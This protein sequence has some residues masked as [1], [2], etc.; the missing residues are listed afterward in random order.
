MKNASLLLL[1]TILVVVSARASESKMSYLDN[2]EIRLGVDLSKGGAVTYLAD[3][4]SKENVINSWDWGRQI[5][6]SFYSGPVPFAPD[7]ATLAP[8]WKDLGWNPIQS[9]DHYK[10]GSQVVEYH[11]DGKTIFVRCIPMI[12]P[13]DNV[14]AESFFETTYKLNGRTVEVTARLINHREDT[15]QYPARQQELPA[16][17]TNGPWYRLVTYMGDRPFTSGEVTALV[18]RE[19]GKGWPWLQFY[20]SERWA[21]LLNDENEGLGVYHPSACWMSGGFAGI[22]GA[23]G[24]ADDP[25]GYLSP[26]HTEILDA[27]IDYTYRYTLILGSLAEIRDYVYAQHREKDL[28][29]WTFSKDRQ[30][31]H[32]ENTTD[33]GW[34]I[35]GELKVQSG[36]EAGMVSP[37]TFW[38]AEEA[39]FLD[40]EAAFPAEAKTFQIIIEPYSKLDS[41]AWEAW[42]ETGKRPSSPRLTPLVIDVKPGASINLYHVNLSQLEGYRGAMVRIRVKL[43]IESGTAHVRSLALRRK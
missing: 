4:E 25:T 13:L 23:G 36:P 15:T 19:N 17:Y 26:L 39:S 34:P 6:M 2:G 22:K 29:A 8:M 5:Q 10:H 3:S 37:H 7:G 33:S 12:W 24:P 1:S 42:G 21:A 31:W 38:L 30:H 27:T 40:V 16:V 43:P 20:S 9:G 32:Y 35:Q 18:D 11:N 14:P 28:P 41:R